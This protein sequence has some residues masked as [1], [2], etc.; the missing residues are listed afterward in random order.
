[1]SWSKCYN[2]IL[3]YVFAIE[4]PQGS[5]SG[6]F[7]AYNETK[8]IAAFATAAHVIEQ[9]HSWKLPIKLRQETT[10]K[11]VFL[12]DEMR[13]IEFDK[14]RDSAAIFIQSGHFDLPQEMLSMIEN[15]RY[16][17]TG[18]EV[19][20]VG[21]PSIA[22]PQLCFF[23]GRISGFIHEQD[24]YLIDGV[25][26]N[27]VSG[28]PVFACLE[29]DKPK[30]LGTI[31]AYVPNRV[32]GESLPG[33]LRSQDVTTFHTAIKKMNNFDEEWKRAQEEQEKSSKEQ[34]VEPDSKSDNK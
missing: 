6:F 30:I 13:L 33:L 29:G 11:E 15:D 18:E 2:N 25:A 10:G 20:W 16:R 28:G 24:T 17:A 9:A 21:Y 22:S 14:K 3:P 32:Y 5:G 26:I 8:V 1:M 19:G 23:T 34:I 31:S 27:G 7:L 12:T 4:T